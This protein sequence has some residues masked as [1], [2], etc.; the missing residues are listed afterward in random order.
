MVSF[1]T[2]SL[3]LRW[4]RPN[5]LNGVFAAYELRYAGDDS[6]DTNVMERLLFSSTF[7]ITGV[8]MGV[9]FRAA[10]RA[11]TVSLTGETLWGPF[12]VLRVVD[13]K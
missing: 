8:E 12:S 10:V 3:S 11:S 4:G 9:V 13:G 1:T 5:P 6:F 2:S 7:T